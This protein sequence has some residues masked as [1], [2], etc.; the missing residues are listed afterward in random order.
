MPN[1]VQ[2]L[3]TYTQGVS[4]CWVTP[5][6]NQSPKKLAEDSFLSPKE[7]VTNKKYDQMRKKSQKRVPCSLT[8]YHDATFFPS[9]VTGVTNPARPFFVCDTNVSL[10]L[11]AQQ[12]K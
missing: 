5:C 9:S 1:Y 4:T 11:H 6:I 10:V 8:V 3:Y 12:V 7:V 2:H